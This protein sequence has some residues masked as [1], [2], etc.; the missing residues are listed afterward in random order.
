MAAQ[1]YIGVGG[2]ASDGDGQSIA[3]WNSSIEWLKKKDTTILEYSTLL[4]SKYCKCIRS[5]S[6]D[7]SD[8]LDTNR[9][10]SII[11]THLGLPRVSKILKNMLQM[12]LLCS[13]AKNW[14]KFA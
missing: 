12:K 1:N 4:L 8:C 14:I 2:N 10:H 6:Q 9:F 5:W 13:S 7:H 11:D 3:G